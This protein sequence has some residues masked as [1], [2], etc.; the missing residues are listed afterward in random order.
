MKVT[1]SKSVWYSVF[2]LS[3]VRFSYFMDFMIMMPLGRQIMSHM[4]LSTGQFGIIVS[5]FTIAAGISGLLG[6]LVIDRFSKKSSLLFAFTNFTIATYICGISNSF[7]V[8]LVARIYAGTFGGLI[9]A[10]IYS[11]TSD[12]VD[13]NNKGKA[14]GMLMAASSL[15]FILG[16]SFSIYSVR[17]MGNWSAPFTLLSF[18]CFAILLF[19]AK[20]LP[21]K[22]PKGKSQDSIWTPYIAI[23]NNSSMSMACVLVVLFALGQYAIIPYIS[24]YLELNL[25]VSEEQ[26]AVLLSLGGFFSVFSSILV[27]KLTDS[28]GKHFMAKLL[29]TLSI[30]S[31]FLITNISSSNIFIIGLMVIFFFVTITGRL[32]PGQALVSSVAP[33]QFQSSF[34]SV[35]N[36]IQQFASGLASYL[37]S[38]VIVKENYKIA[39]LNL[40]GLLTISITLLSYYVVHSLKRNKNVH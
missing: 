18:I 22:K 15:A 35:Q 4:N 38:L 37:G 32:V 23:Y 2:L 30:V 10:L 33:P 5:S 39:H 27:G 24:P 13:Y 20:N 25:G 17:I 21:K 1:M 8:L 7:Y 28:I 31:T 9:T 14:M 6:A 3:L 40:L 29:I 36:S 34:M 16:P 11:I 12:I 19:A 26:L